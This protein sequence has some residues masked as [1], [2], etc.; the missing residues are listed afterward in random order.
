MELTD[1]RNVLT[2]LEVIEGRSFTPQQTDA[3]FEILGRHSEQD[4][5]EAVLAFHSKPFKRPAYP[6]DI[7]AHIIEV[8]AVR[9]RRCGTLELSQTDQVA[10][11]ADASLERLRSLVASGEWTAA[12]YREYR[13]SGLSLEEFD[14]ARGALP[15]G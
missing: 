13:R 1:L 10:G 11:S 12:E 14:T 9:L 6:G 15:V 7:K 8:E 3:W 5:T 4:A 2:K